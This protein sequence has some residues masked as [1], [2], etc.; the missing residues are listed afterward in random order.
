MSPVL[1]NQAAAIPPSGIR[2]LANAAWATPDALH[3]EFGEPDFDTPAHIVEAAGRAARQ[4]RTRYSPS[5]GLPA[6]REAVT[7]KLA[8][9]NGLDGVAADQV[10]ITPG[11]V[12][13]LACAYRA[14]LDAGDEILVPG[15]GWPNLASI[16]LTVG[17][18]PVFY[19]SLKDLD[20]LV[21]D[22]TRAVVINT[23]SNP[24]GAVLE[25]ADQAALG[26]WAASRGL[27][28]IADECYDQLWFDRPN[29]TFAVAAPGVPA[30]TVFSFSKT[31]AMT[32]WR[33]GYTVAPAEVTARMTRV[34]E[35]V[36]SS[37]STPTQWAG[38]TA[39]TGPQE[40]VTRMRDAYRDR[41]DAAVATA[42]ELGLAHTAPAGAFYLWLDSDVDALDLLR[43]TGV[44]V[45]PGTAFGPGGAGHLR[46]SLA[47]AT[48]DIRRGLAAIASFEGAR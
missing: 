30:I 17:A 14:V 47:A 39:L 20:A 10:L 29:T 27:W 2:A 1:G 35:T 12:G 7:E 28:V 21:T 33:L 13:G 18:R 5:A 48:D 40:T 8:R 36:G 6:L 43:A 26:A 25:A 11:G 4:G 23:P 19:G 24:T 41:R 15:P 38:V 42:T 9:D 34:L 44:A 31:Y 22:R 37:V 46:V 32:G 16:A 3:L 45:A